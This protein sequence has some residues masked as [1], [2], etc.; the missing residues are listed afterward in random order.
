[1]KNQDTAHQKQEIKQI[2]LKVKIKVVLNNVRLFLNTICLG[3][4]TMIFFAGFLF[5]LSPDEFV[6]IKD[7]L[8]DEEIITML[9]GLILLIISLIG[10]AIANF[11]S[12]HILKYDCHKLLYCLM[13]SLFSIFANHILPI[14]FGLVLFTLII[15]IFDLYQVN[16]DY[17]DHLIILGRPGDSK[18]MFVD[19]RTFENMDCVAV[20]PEIGKESDAK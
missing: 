5:Y 1:M 12:I 16:E 20:D 10:F 15:I 14:I 2:A 4:A 9:T 18:N 13:F 11:K 19:R 7:H 8:L 6:E 3:I 17:Q